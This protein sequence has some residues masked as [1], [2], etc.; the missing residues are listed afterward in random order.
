MFD[1]SNPSSPFITATIS[2]DNAWAVELDEGLLYVANED[3]IL[4]YNILNLI[5]PIHEMFM[6]NA[7]K[8]LLIDNGF[9]YVALG[10]NGVDIYNLS[11]P[12]DPQYLDNYNTTT[13]AIRLAAFSTKL[14]VTDWDDIEILEYSNGELNLVGYKNTTRRTMALATKENYIYSGEWASVQIFEY[15]EIDGAD[16]DLDLYELNYPFVEAFSVLFPKKFLHDHVYASCHKQ[17][18]LPY[19][20]F[21]FVSDLL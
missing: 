17:I 5:S 10:S 16:I 9:L 12:E 14:A 4:I 11:D 6:T 7:V 19:Q 18:V 15:G 20:L 2:A 21:L 13:L 3:K 8:D 1:I